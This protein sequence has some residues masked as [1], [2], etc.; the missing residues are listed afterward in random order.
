M[1]AVQDLDED[2]FKTKKNTETEQSI[3]IGINHIIYYVPT[4][5]TVEDMLQCHEEFEEVC[6][7]V[8][9]ITI[10]EMIGDALDPMYFAYTSK[11]AQKQL[12]MGLN[13][14]VEIANILKECK[15][16][17]LVQRVSNVC[18]SLCFVTLIGKLCL[19][20]DCLMFAQYCNPTTLY[21][22]DIRY[23]VLQ[24]Q[25]VTI[26]LRSTT[27]TLPERTGETAALLYCCEATGHIRTEKF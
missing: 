15:F 25:D 21:N 16:L 1:S 27:I 2:S 3:F 5:D 19:L 24:G 11:A 6:Y 8:G 10:M 23:I 17:H 7:T 18:T 14:G 13:L 26:E 20:F 22:T 4:F 9:Y 12:E